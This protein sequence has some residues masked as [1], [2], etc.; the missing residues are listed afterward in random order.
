MKFYIENLGKIDDADIELKDLTIICGPNSS[1]KTWLSYLI[2]RMLD[3]TYSTAGLGNDS[4]ETTKLISDAIEYGEAKISLDTAVT[5]IKERAKSSI[6]KTKSNLHQYFN[7]EKSVLNDLSVEVDLSFLEQC[8]FQYSEWES[9]GFLFT[10]TKENIT[11][12]KIEGFII[13]DEDELEEYVNHLTVSFISFASL[14][15]SNFKYGRAFLA[16]SER[17][18][19]LIF[20]PDLDRTTLLLDEMLKSID[21]L[22]IEPEEKSSFISSL[23]A[24]LYSAKSRA[25][26]P[27]R[28]NISDIRESQEIMKE[29]GY[30]T[31][32][33]SEVLEVLEQLNGGSF[34]CSDEDILYTSND[35][36]YKI[37]SSSS[38]I[39]SLYLID[40]YIRHKLNVN[41]TLLIDEPELNLH[42]NNQ[43]LMAKLIVR[44][45]N[46]G[47]RVVITTHSDFI[48]REINNSIM[49]SQDFSEKDSL[50]V[51][52]NLLDCDIL[53]GNK[54]NSYTVNTDGKVNKMEML[55]T[56]IDSKIFDNIILEAN[57]LQEDLFDALE[58]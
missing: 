43:R 42:P 4:D 35:Q 40:L 7:V 1:N 25:S 8:D 13:P 27:V 28:R 38:S 3:A 11:L 39:K 2:C 19:A 21:K 12:K 45:V 20:Q 22:D 9:E 29:S 53:D 33:H 52:H 16:S 23:A 58:D 14:N 50:M 47:I 44:L 54:V 17:T 26:V 41:D 57:Q 34:K 37:S 18:G 48:I 36:T 15:F 24:K 5:E 49:L 55:D 6:S 31:E 46:A 51:Q 56:G 10:L 32:H 30:I